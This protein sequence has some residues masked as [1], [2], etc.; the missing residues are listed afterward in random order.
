MGVKGPGRVQITIRSHRTSYGRTM[1][2]FSMTHV[3]EK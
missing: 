3:Y 1:S 2:K